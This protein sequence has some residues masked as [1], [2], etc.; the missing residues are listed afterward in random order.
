MLYGMTYAFEVGPM[1]HDDENI[2]FPLPGAPPAVDVV[3]RVD[4]DSMAEL[5]LETI[6]A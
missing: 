5:Y 2:S 1:T 4:L 6:G 3:Y